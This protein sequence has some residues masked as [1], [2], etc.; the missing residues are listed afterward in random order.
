VQKVHILPVSGRGLLF[1]QRVVSLAISQRRIQVFAIAVAGKRARLTHQPL[2]D[3]P[4]IDP[5]LVLTT[6]ARQP[7]HQLLG[8]PDLDLV[9]AKAGL[10]FFALQ[11]RGHRI[12]VVVDAN[13]A[14]TP[15]PY[16]LTL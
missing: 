6:H 13:G 2:D 3:V 12:G 8:I 9:Q 11:P 16:P 14:A 4:I 15:Y 1:D 7:L 5:V 10:D